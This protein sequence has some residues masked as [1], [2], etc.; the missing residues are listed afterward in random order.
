MKMKIAKAFVLVGVLSLGAGP[1]LGAEIRNVGGAD[2]DIQPA[3]D[4]AVKKK[5]DR[6]LKHWKQVQV[7][8]RKGQSAYP[9]LLCDIEGLKTEIALKHCP[10]G[11]LDLLDQ[12]A[13]LEAEMK[14]ARDNE[15]AASRAV[16]NA[17]RK[18][19]V[20]Q[21]KRSQT[22]AKDT[23][24]SLSKQLVSLDQKVKREQKIFAM[25][26]GATFDGVPLWDTGLRSP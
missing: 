11:I 24:K 12:K 19:E 16:G 17:T 25:F 18:R 9:V 7:L 1:G 26:T 2:V 13:T 21:A 23:E 22:A 8:E 6:P 3:I 4:W 5:G 14:A 20:R 15:E 10:R